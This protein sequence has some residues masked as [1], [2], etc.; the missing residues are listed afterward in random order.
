MERGLAF[1]M[2]SQNSGAKKPLIL[3][4]DNGNKKREFRE[5]VPFLK[6]GDFV[7][8]HDWGS[9]FL[10][11]DVIYWVNDLLGDVCDKFGS[12]TRFFE[13]V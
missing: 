5:F 13:V 6:S 12:R 10:Q 8:V 3:F 4:C 9:E 1:S 7:V 2:A 11:K